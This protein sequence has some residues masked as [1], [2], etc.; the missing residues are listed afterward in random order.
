MEKVGR[1][2]KTEVPSTTSTQKKLNKSH[3]AIYC[4]IQYTVTICK[5]I[6]EDLSVLKTKACFLHQNW[7]GWAEK[8]KLKYHQLL[9]H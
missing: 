8:P 6:A 1:K 3:F 7:K 2:T 5:D 4:K 9:Q